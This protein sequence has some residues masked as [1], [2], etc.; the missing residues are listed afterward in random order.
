MVGIWSAVVAGLMVLSQSLGVRRGPDDPAVA[1][2]KAD[3]AKADR[4]LGATLIFL[5]ALFLVGGFWVDLFVTIGLVCIALGK[6]TD[7]G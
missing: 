1:V 2:Y 5:V 6:I 4:R 3:V 7:L